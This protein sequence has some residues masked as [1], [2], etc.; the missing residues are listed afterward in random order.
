MDEEDPTCYT[1]I[2]GHHFNW[3]ISPVTACRLAQRTRPAQW[4]A[5]TQVR[6]TDVRSICIIS[7]QGNSTG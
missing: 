4:P 2:Q 6:W 7:H 1:P 3:H 5:S